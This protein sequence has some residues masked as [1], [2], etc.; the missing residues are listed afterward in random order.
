MPSQKFTLHVRVLSAKFCTQIPLY[1]KARIGTL[2]CVGKWKFEWF[3][4][5]FNKQYKKS[6]KKKELCLLSHILTSNEMTGFISNPFTWILSNILL[7][8][9]VKSP[10]DKLQ[11]NSPF[12]GRVMWWRSDIQWCSPGF[13]FAA[14]PW[15]LHCL[16][17]RC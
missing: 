5:I 13:I 17:D 10:P 15:W 2:D 1:M 4:F 8:V 16:V 9:P 11:T 7:L 6:K 14:E 3:L 12:T